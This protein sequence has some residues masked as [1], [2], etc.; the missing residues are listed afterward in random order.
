MSENEKKEVGLHLKPRTQLIAAVAAGAVILALLIVVICVA[1]TCGKKTSAKVEAFAAPQN[2]Q[3]Q[4][5]TL[6]WSAVEG[7]A[8]GYTVRVNGSADKIV[9]VS[10]AAGTSL[11]L[12]GVVQ[13]YFDT[14][15]NTLAVKANAVTDG[16]TES[17][18]SAEVTYTFDGSN[19]EETPQLPRLPRPENARI[20]GEKL[21]WNAV[22]GVS[23][24]VVYTL[25]EGSSEVRVTGTELHLFAEGVAESLKLV[26]GA[27]VEIYV[28]VP[29]DATHRESLSSVV[30]HII[31]AE[32]EAVK[33]QKIAAARKETAACAQSLAG[34]SD[35]QVF[36]AATAFAATFKAYDDYVK[37]DSAVAASYAEI[38]AA[39]T[40]AKTN[41]ETTTTQKHTE[42]QELLDKQYGAQKPTLADHQALQAAA[43]WIA[44]LQ[45]GTYAHAYWQEQHADTAAQVQSKIA[46]VEKI[47]VQETE[48]VQAFVDGA[49]GTVTILYSALNVLGEG[50]VFDG[51]PALR[52][53]VDGATLQEDAA[54]TFT[55]KNGTYVYTAS[56]GKKADADY[57]LQVKYAIGEGDEKT[58]TYKEFLDNIYFVPDAFHAVADG[59]IQYS[60]APGD[61]AFFD[62]YEASAISH[63]GVLPQITARPLLSGIAVKNGMAIDEFRRM[64]ARSYANILIDKVFEVK[65]VVY[66]KTVDE[67]G[68]ITMSNIKNALVGH[69]VYTLDLTAEDAK[70]PLTNSVLDLGVWPGTGN[71][72]LI[73]QDQVEAYVAQLNDVVDGVTV[74]ADNAR[75]YLKIRIDV[76]DDDADG[77]V[78]FSKDVPFANQAYDYYTLMKE[79]SS[80]YF[81]NGGEDGAMAHFKLTLTIGLTQTVNGEANP[82]GAYFRDAAPKDVSKGQVYNGEHTFNKA[83]VTVPNDIQFDLTNE[84]IFFRGFT[85]ANDIISGLVSHLEL[86]FAPSADTQEY[87]TAYVLYHKENDAFYLHKEANGSDAGQALIKGG[88]EYY[89]SG[90]DLNIWINA[91]YF[92]G[93]N[94]FN[95]TTGGWYFATQAV[96][97][98]D[99]DTYLY[100][101]GLSAW[102]QIGGAQE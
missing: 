53:T 89:L 37:E 64:L 52:V 71:F 56:F 66:T 67:T 23:E 1:V 46:A 82:L 94:T 19:E 74:T 102:Q 7:A 61:E 41:I 73:V 63:S 83:D 12:S 25:E 43:A 101:D 21:L 80:H 13:K 22:A 45:E 85:M 90:N 96:D 79:W 29:A 62:V 50:I 72:S 55:D 28:K 49:N 11:S 10:A 100:G 48:D 44:D 92:G 60:G 39:L 57:Q 95:I 33:E 99:D 51:S 68:A 24:Y 58:V 15:A 34:K 26:A 88:N 70:M 81:K 35:E 42:I 47:P 32:S 97:N 14:G 4:G 5:D 6:Q 78:V 59:K 3:V 54:A 65:F 86:R 30:V 91:Q 69:D 16:K 17:A 76:L 77:A 93:E 87:H 20:E 27:T 40:A 9:G 98:P 75:D 8:A 31:P 84:P 38:T 36:A 18:Y 2:V